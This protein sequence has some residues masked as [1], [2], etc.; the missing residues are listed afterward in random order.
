MRNVM[1]NEAGKEKSHFSTSSLKCKPQPKAATPKVTH[2]FL[3]QQLFSALLANIK[4]PLLY[5][6]TKHAAAFAYLEHCNRSLEL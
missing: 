6:I 5:R 3:A 1:C 4:S 2:K